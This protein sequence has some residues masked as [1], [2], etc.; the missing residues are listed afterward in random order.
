MIDMSTVGLP[1]QKKYSDSTLK[2]WNKDELIR[3]IRILEGNYNAAIWFNE[4]QARNFQTML[5]YMSGEHEEVE[6]AE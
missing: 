6:V 3:Y 4:Q 2:T 5:E 1:T